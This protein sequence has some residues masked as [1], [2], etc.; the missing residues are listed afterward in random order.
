MKN[1]LHNIASYKLI[2]GDLFESIKKQH[3]DAIVPHVVSNS[4]KFSSGFAAAVEKNYPIV[5]ANYEMLSTYKLGEN[6]FIKIDAGNR[7]SIIFVNM[8]AQNS[9]ARRGKRQLN[10]LSLVKCMALISTYIRNNYSEIDSNK[11]EIHAPK[12]G[13]GFAGG[14][15]NF[16]SDLIDDVWGDYTTYVYTPKRD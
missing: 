14:N 10:Y 6:Q 4:G 13:C 9:N 7:R 2:F 5:K 16:I 3:T 11:V 1:N 12:F 15:W 8:I